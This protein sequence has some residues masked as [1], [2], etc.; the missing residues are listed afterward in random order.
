MSPQIR[1][2][3]F[4]L[5]EGIVDR[6]AEKDAAPDIEE[7][8]LPCRRVAVSADTLSPSGYS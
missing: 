2:P 6:S 8:L 5:F 7:R 3:F 4:Q 1:F